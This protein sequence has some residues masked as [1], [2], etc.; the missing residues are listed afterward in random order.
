MW[1]PEGGRCR[2]D[3]T[4]SPRRSASLRAV[5]RIPPLF[6]LGL[7]LLGCEEPPPPAYE[8][9]TPPP[10]TYT[11]P[12]RAAAS[13]GDYAALCSANEPFPAAKP[14]KKGATPADISR[15]A[16][17]QRWN[18]SVE[19]R[20]EEI[21]GGALDPVSTSDA[22]EVQL[23][24]CAEVSKRALRR[25]CSFQ[26]GYTL[27]LYDLSHSVRVLEAA[28]GKVVLEQTFEL[29]SVETC[30]TFESFGSSS[31]YRGTDSV[32]KLLALLLTLQ[33]AGVKTDPPRSYLDLGK[34][35]AGVPF[36]G[37]APYDKTA[38]EKHPIYV[39]FRADESAPYHYE[40][41]PENVDGP[42]ERLDDPSKYQLVACVTGK[43]EKKRKQCRFDGGVVLEL[44]TGT[45]E[46]A[47]YASAT[48][49]LVE[50][51]TFKVA[52]GSCPFIFSFPAGADR[53]IWLP[54]IEPAYGKY[55]DTLVG[56]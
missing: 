44:H 34:V 37:T 26:E 6:A 46:V 33:P 5:T 47:V 19:P 13:I 18:E 8:P 29:P 32:P 39:A 48:A 40:N 11:P 12:P 2:N 49:E 9:E 43:P 38:A 25:S 15:V 52:G 35:C 42:G 55:L 14:Y 7:A 10:E 20:W 3:S 51:R 56:K 4:C 41:T 45:V 31:T 54:K 17:F 28:T 50:K 53:A 22:K 36:P 24:A 16:V 23:V 30:P 27:D 21:G 1:T